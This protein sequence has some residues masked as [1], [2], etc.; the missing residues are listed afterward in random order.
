[1]H[2]RIYI[3]PKGYISMVLGILIHGQQDSKEDHVVC[4][5]R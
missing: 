3:K 1:M 4:G 2:T 5:E